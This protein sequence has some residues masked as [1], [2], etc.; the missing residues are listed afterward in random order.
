VTVSPSTATTTPSAPGGGS[1]QGGGGGG[2]GEEVEVLGE[3]VSTGPVVQ[4]T[5]PTSINAGLTEDGSDRNA[6]LP[7][8][9]AT[10]GGLLGLLALVLRRRQA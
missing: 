8:G 2:G 7:L 9:L 4:G 6:A 5:V 1:N 3:Q 10:L